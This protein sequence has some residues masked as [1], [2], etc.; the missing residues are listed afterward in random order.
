[1]H[2]HPRV[3]K[4][5]QRTNINSILEKVSYSIM[6]DDWNDIDFSNL[7]KNL[8]KGRD[9]GHVPQQQPRKS[10]YSQQSRVALGDV[11]AHDPSRNKSVTELNRLG[12]QVERPV[13]LFTS[14]NRSSLQS[15]S[16]DKYKATTPFRSDRSSQKSLEM[17][18]AKGN[19]SESSRSSLVTKPTLSRYCESPDD[20]VMDSMAD[21]SNKA[22][23]LRNQS[24]LVQDRLRKGLQPRRSF[25]DKQSEHTLDSR[26]AKV[27]SADD[28]FAGLAIPAGRR[29]V[30]PKKAS[31]RPS[32]GTGFESDSESWTELCLKVGA[33]E[34]QDR[35]SSR[36]STDS[37][38]LSVSVSSVL[39]SDD[40]FDGVELP[41]NLS[42][43]RKRLQAINDRRAAGDTIKLAKPRDED[44]SEGLL[45]DED[46]FYSAP[47]LIHQ[48][49]KKFSAKRPT[50]IQSPELYRSLRPSRLPV[51]GPRH[52]NRDASIVQ[53]RHAGIAKAEGPEGSQSIRY[54]RSDA[55]LRSEKHGTDSEGPTLAS[56]ARSVARPN[57]GAQQRPAF[58][59]GGTAGISSYH[60]SARATRNDQ[61]D[62][63]PRMSS[64]RDIAASIRRRA[65]ASEA[66]K[67]E[68]S[69]HLSRTHIR[70]KTYGEGHELDAFEDLATDDRFERRLTAQPKHRQINLSP[71]RSSVKALDLSKYQDTSPR[72]SVCPSSTPGA[73]LRE[74]RQPAS[75][76]PR[77]TG[78]MTPDQK[79]AKKRKPNLPGLISGINTTPVARVE[80]NMSYNPVT[81]RWEGNEDEEMSRFDTVTSTSRPA[82]ITNPNAATQRTVQVVN[83]MVF[84]P[85]Q[86]CWVKL[87][88]EDSE[89]DPFE[90]L[91]DLPDSS[92]NT[93]PGRK[94]NTTG[95]GYTGEFT[96]GEEFDVG[97]LFIRRQREEEVKWRRATSNWIQPRSQGSRRAYLH[98][99]YD[100]LMD[101]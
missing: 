100:L 63:L 47:I 35:R 9:R 6:N 1:M 66:L 44:P 92:L 13:S 85:D 91:D 84:D 29:L 28:D 18:G 20:S 81:F 54:K 95:Q 37:S 59:P 8:S 70:A 12:L 52:C 88:D 30:L 65:T 48:N 22:I 60:I 79:R 32:A 57:R 43:L 61:A 16:G 101:D 71:A 40:D 76:R 78:L 42:E 53:T 3:A 99:I 23:R 45:L 41:E 58:V 39:A 11:N 2:R 96:V 98:E 64:S 26:A 19:I 93:G 69:K 10:V 86:M 80:K 56:L 55:S 21:T 33:S 97:P 50:D 87:S 46:V 27:S 73:A 31:G 90:G 38:S 15:V 77:N 72:K 94:E 83:G 5:Q 62:S 7:E 4:L 89:K 25:P 75:M 67:L 68:A 49:L 74:L 17:Q 51:P 82:L 36:N 24:T 14:K 34:R